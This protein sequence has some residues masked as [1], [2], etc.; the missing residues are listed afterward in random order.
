MSQVATIDLDTV[1]LDEMGLVVIDALDPKLLFQPG[2]V[3]A[4]VQLITDAALAV[5]QDVSTP[6]GREAI[7]AL[8]YKVSRSKTAIEDIGSR[9]TEG[10]RAQT[11]SINASKKLAQQKLDYLRDRLKAPVIA[12]DRAE[13]ARK[14]AHENAL[15]DIVDL[16]TLPPDCTPAQLRELLAMLQALPKRDW[17]EFANLAAD[18]FARA[19]DILNKALPAAEARQAEREELERLRREEKERKRLAA[20]EARAAAEDAEAAKLQAEVAAVGLEPAL[21]ARAAS[22]QQAAPAPVEPAATAPQWLSERGGGITSDNRRSVHVAV[23]D[24]FCVA[25]GIP[26]AAASKIL[27]AIVRG[28]VPHVLITY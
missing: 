21:A 16:C 23:V 14:D 15:H 3:A 12:Y 1:P 13:Q 2:G 11:A 20:Y 17:E 10:W 9:I 24:A 8:A 19:E 18:A 27:T 28:Q 6:A 22:A 25:G 4:V 7:R 26:R 5:P